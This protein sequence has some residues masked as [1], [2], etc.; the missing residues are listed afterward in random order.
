LMAIHRAAASP[1]A[2]AR[3]GRFIPMAPEAPPFLLWQEPDPLRGRESPLAP[4]PSK[5]NR[6]ARVSPHNLDLS[7]ELFQPGTAQISPN[8]RAVRSRPPPPTNQNPG[9]ARTHDPAA[10]FPEAASPALRPP[11]HWV[12][13][14]PAAVPSLETRRR[15]FFVLR[16]ADPGEVPLFFPSPPSDNRGF[17]QEAQPRGPSPPG[18]VETLRRCPRLSPGEGD[19][20]Q[21]PNSKRH[22]ALEPANSALCSL[23]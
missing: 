16:P 9:Q 10:V 14:E 6:A 7:P 21:L 1:D 15:R 12:H 18:K 8:R 2:P 11:G 23:L 19:R 22:E 20:P 5:R 4:K 13:A 3:W 17:C